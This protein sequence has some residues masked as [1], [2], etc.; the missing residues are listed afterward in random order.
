MKNGEPINAEVIID[1]A[2]KV[3]ESVLPKPGETS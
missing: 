2:F 1:E 3:Q